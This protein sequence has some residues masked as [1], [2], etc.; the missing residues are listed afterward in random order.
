MGL[1]DSNPEPVMAN[2]AEL[3]ALKLKDATQQSSPKPLMK[4]KAKVSDEILLAN[5]FPEGLFATRVS[6]SMT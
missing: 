4:P 1:S 6:G 3:A 2:R 5:L